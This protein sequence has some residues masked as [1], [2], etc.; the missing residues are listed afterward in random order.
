[1]KENILERNMKSMN[2]RKYAY[3]EC[4]LFYMKEYMLSITFHSNDVIFVKIPLHA[5]E[6]SPSKLFSAEG[7]ARTNINF[8]LKC[9]I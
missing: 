2:E 6:C 7:F 3:R 1:M 9:C 5:V 8:K 4:N